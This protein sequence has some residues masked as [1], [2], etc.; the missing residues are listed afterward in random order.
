MNSLRARQLV[1]TLV[2]II[3]GILMLGFAMTKYKEREALDAR[4]TQLQDLS[5]NILGYF[6]FERGKF[7]IDNKAALEEYLRVKG[8]KYNGNEANLA[9]LEHVST[10][11][12]HWHS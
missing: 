5:E 12:I 3:I 7:K 10:K 1:S 9:Y 6:L 4:K 8:F 2:V 11:E